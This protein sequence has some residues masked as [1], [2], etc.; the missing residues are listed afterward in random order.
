MK[1]VFL[2]VIILSMHSLCW[3]G[4]PSESSGSNKYRDDGYG[5]HIAVEIRVNNEFRGIVGHLEYTGIIGTVDIVTF[6]GMV[7]VITQAE[8]CKIVQKTI[9]RRAFIISGVRINTELSLQ[10]PLTFTILQSQR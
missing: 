7:Q 2:F 6:Q 10:A 4:D 1:R 9:N 5:T 3:G 8:V